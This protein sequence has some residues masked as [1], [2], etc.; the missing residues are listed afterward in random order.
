MA[1]GFVAATFP[2]GEFVCADDDFE[3]VVID[4]FLMCDFFMGRL[5]PAVL[6]RALVLLDDIGSSVACDGIGAVTTSSPK[7]G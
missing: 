1:A 6:R 7:T 2:R 4:L 3:T 5:R